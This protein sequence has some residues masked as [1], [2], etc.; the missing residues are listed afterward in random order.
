MIRMNYA[1]FRTASKQVSKEGELCELSE[2]L[3]FIYH[4]G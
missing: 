1:C 4:K 2:F 3:H